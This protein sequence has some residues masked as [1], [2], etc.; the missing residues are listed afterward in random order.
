MKYDISGDDSVAKATPF[1]ISELA[2]GCAP[3][4]THTHTEKY[5]KGADVCLRMCS[6]NKDDVLSMSLLKE[7]WLQNK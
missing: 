5:K 4:V 3:G 2:Y 7:R 6:L 1:S